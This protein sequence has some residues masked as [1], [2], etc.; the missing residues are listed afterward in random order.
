[1]S[2]NHYTPNGGKNSSGQGWQYNNQGSGQRGGSGRSGGQPPK[3]PDFDIGEWI[4][5]II[6]FCLPFGVT[7]LIAFFWALSKVIHIVKRNKDYQEQLKK[8]GRAAADIT[9]DVSDAVRREV[10]NAKKAS[11]SAKAG[12]ASQ[13]TSSPGTGSGTKAGSQAYTYAGSGRPAA[14]KMGKQPK[15][16]KGLIT[17][18]TIISAIFG[19]ST[20]GAG[21]VFMESLMMGYFF[22]DELIGA[23]VCALFLCGGLAI[24]FKGIGNNRRKERCLNYLAYIGA[25]QEVNLAHMAAAFD[26]PVK[27]LCKDL[28][29]MLSEGI[30]PTGYLDLA[31]GK[32]FLTEMGYRAPEPEAAREKSAEEVKKEEDDILREIRQINDDI[33]DEVMSAKIDRIEEITRKILA[34]QKSHPERSSQLRSFLNYYLPTTLKI[35]RAYAQ[36]DAQGI[37]G[38][39]ISAAKARIEGMMDQVV[40]GFEKQLD[41]LFQDDAM[42]IS[43]DVQVLENMLK[44]DGLS[45]DSQNMT[46]TL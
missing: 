36:L 10:N 37:E 25:N 4:P 13:S 28:R 20:L 27:K 1:M 14:R 46:M 15:G 45:D 12:G 9:H 8:F 21:S 11:E 17:L 33:P 26:V 40:A 22:S 30:L 44:K 38:E 5:I 29:Y 31:A 3:K 23:L 18:G 39:N 35:L 43:S 24:L 32:L 42:D 7:Q 2:S 16:G 41:R 19:I 6:L 34:Y